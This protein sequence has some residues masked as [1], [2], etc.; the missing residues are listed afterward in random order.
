MDDHVPGDGNVSRMSLGYV[1]PESVLD[2]VRI[3]NTDQNLKSG[4][5]AVW[6]K[7][8]DTVRFL[9]LLEILEDVSK[10]FLKDNVVPAGDDRS[11][12]TNNNCLQQMKND[13]D[14]SKMAFDGIALESIAKLYS[15]DKIESSALNTAVFLFEWDKEIK[16]TRAPGRLDV[17][18]GIADYSGSL[19]LQKTIAEAAHVA[20]QTKSPG[21]QLHIANGPTLRIISVLSHSKDRKPVVDVK[22][23][24]LYKLNNHPISYDEVGIGFS[25]FS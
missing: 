18:G 20:I 6:K 14:F 24:D 2:R 5:N 7:C 23:S 19:V 25:M 10:N 1:A 16:I 9:K 12:A 13:A 3:V 21:L 4:N 22:I 15:L 17:M 11:L 8:L